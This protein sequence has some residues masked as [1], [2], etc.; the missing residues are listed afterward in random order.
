MAITYI[1]PANFSRFLIL[2]LA[3]FFV[4]SC[5][6]QLRGALEISDDMSPLY[7]QQ[8][9]AFELARELKQLLATNK[10]A[11]TVNSSKANSWLVLLNENRQRRVL[12]VDGSGRA[13][14]YLLTYTVDFSI[15][16]DQAD[17]E[18]IKEGDKIKE[19]VES[20]SVSRTLLF[21]VNAVLAVANESEI[22]YEDMRRDV[23]RLIL[24]KLQARAKPGNTQQ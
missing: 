21:D 20:I 8:N 3:I 11:V 16:V 19:I 18:K 23:A 7:L 1:A 2:L 13:K 12:S 14:E 5:G 24:L 15:R 10:I 4:Q 22:L 6:F 9:S 17:G